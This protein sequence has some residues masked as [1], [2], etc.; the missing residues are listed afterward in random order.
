MTGDI[1]KQQQAEALLLDALAEVT[2]RP[3]SDFSL[4]QRFRD[5]A[6]PS[7]D[8][9]QV[10]YEVETRMQI[11]LPVD[12]AVELSDKTLS[13]LALLCSQLPTTA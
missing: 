10:V 7:L 13:E 3:R 9:L 1:E 4:E 8:V 11:E 12:A 6:I 5:L 2:Q